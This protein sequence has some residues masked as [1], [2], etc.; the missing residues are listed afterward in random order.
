MRAQSL[1]LIRAGRALQA[2]SGN[3][4]LC[5]CPRPYPLRACAAMTAVGA[6]L[7]CVGDAGPPAGAA[8]IDTLSNGTVLVANTGTGVWEPETRWTLRETCRI[9][10][11]DAEGPEQLNEI[12]GLASD[13][14]GRVYILDRQAQD[15]RVFTRDGLFVRTI[16]R[17]G[18]GPGEFQQAN[19]LLFDRRGH[20]WVVDPGN[21]RYSM[22]DT[23]GVLIDTRPRPITSYGY[24]SDA[25]FTTTGALVEHAFRYL[26]VSADGRPDAVPVLVRMNVDTALAVIDTIDTP[27]AG[28]NEIFEIRREQNGRLVGMMQ[29]LVPY[30]PTQQSV[31]D[32]QG[33]IWSGRND[34]YRIWKIDFDGDSVRAVQNVVEL[35]PVTAEERQEEIDRIREAAGEGAR[36]LDFNRI[37]EFRPAYRKVLVDDLGY[38]W[39]WREAQSDSAAFDIF[40]PEGQL[41]GVLETG[42]RIYEYGPIEVRGRMLTA[43][44]RDELDIPSV[45][46]FTIEGRPAATELRN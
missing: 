40:D 2:R 21:G 6:I 33:A 43:V 20:L 35:I 16:G 10:G 4:M 30:S 15:I 23:A 28:Q 18:A 14:L 44:V 45:V 13:D 39:V 1:E 22:F 24:V 12:V 31:L 46:C 34:E 9:G 26:G 32:P 42:N 27:R 41:L 29:M 19:G 17:S 11:I 38:L 25:R 5:G 3:R 8:T 7:A 36:Q 37:P